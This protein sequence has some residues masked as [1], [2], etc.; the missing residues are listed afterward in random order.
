MGE[1][2]KGNRFPFELLYRGLRVRVT[3]RGALEFEFS[4]GFQAHLANSESTRTRIR[5]TRRKTADNSGKC[6][7]R[8]AFV[9][10]DLKERKQSA[11]R[12]CLQNDFRRIHQPD[13]SSSFL[14]GL[15]SLHQQTDAAGI[16]PVDAGDFEHN[17]VFAMSDQ[18]VQRLAQAVSGW[19]QHERPAEGQRSDVAMPEH[20]NLQRIHF[21]LPG[22]RNAVFL[23]AGRIGEK[24]LPAKAGAGYHTANGQTESDA[25]SP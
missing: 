17:L 10:V 3:S 25:A 16:Q 18:V 12:Q 2:R 4:D 21:Y 20:R 14:G 19:A 1:I 8:F 23:R 5:L 11:H 9:V 13:R 24:K 7:D 15:E 6:C 22:S